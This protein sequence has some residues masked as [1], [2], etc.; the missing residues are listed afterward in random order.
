MN[1]NHVLT[2]VDPDSGF[3]SL[4]GVRA[5]AAKEILF[6]RRIPIVFKMNVSRCMSRAAGRA[7]RSIRRALLSSI[8]HGPVP[9]GFSI[10]ER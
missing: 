10:R 4:S 2:S 1:Q 7:G 3:P 9:F 8:L 5:F 6:Q